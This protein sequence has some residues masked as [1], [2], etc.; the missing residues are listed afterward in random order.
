MKGRPAVAA[1]AAG[2]LF[3]VGLVL[4]GMTQPA[5]VIGFLDF[6]GEPGTRA[7]RW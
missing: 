6:F 4:G 1:F 5:K 2:L 7:W 3:G